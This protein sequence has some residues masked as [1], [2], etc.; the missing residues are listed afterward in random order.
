MVFE[1]VIFCDVHNAQHKDTEDMEKI[2]RSN[3]WDKAANKSGLH[4]QKNTVYVDTKT[5]L[6]IPYEKGIKT[7]LRIHYEKERDQK[8]IGNLTE[9]RKKSKVYVTSQKEKRKVHLHNKLYFLMF[10]LQWPD[11]PSARL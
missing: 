4:T 6:R 11:M 5:F 1:D 9:K 7:L 2:K 10:T 3:G 8:F